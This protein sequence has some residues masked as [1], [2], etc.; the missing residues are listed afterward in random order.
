MSARS[1]RAIDDLF[2]ANEPFLRAAER[3]R[4]GAM[5]APL[6]A[7]V[8]QLRAFLGRRRGRASRG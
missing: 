7:H 4:K 1:D 6:A 2:P 8:A 5:I 3:A